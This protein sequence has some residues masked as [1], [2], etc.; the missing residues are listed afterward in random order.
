M[1]TALVVSRFFPF[2]SQRVHAVYQR[3]GTQVEALSKVVDNVRVSV[4]GTR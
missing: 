3:L 2:D 4:P 1:S